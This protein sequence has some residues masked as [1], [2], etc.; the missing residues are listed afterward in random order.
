[1]AAPV[2]RP[3]QPTRATWMVCVPWAW[4]AGRATPVRA[5]AAATVL[6]CFKRSRRDG[7]RRSGVLITYL[8][9]GWDE[10]IVPGAP[11]TDKRKT[12]ADSR[13]PLFSPLSPCGRG[14]QPDRLRAA[15]RRHYP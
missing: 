4:T 8:L 13:C 15:T 3:P 7:P 14:P 11:L 5:E 1:M 6:A 2:P 10:L 9:V 12:R